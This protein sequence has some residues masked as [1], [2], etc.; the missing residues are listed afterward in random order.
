MSAPSTCQHVMCSTHALTDDPEVQLTPLPLC[1]KLMISNCLY[2]R[3][4]MQ[5]AFEHILAYC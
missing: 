1:Q 2:E 3:K 5:G 4:H